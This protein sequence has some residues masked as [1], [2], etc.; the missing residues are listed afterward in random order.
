[1]KHLFLAILLLFPIAVYG[2]H[3]HAPAKEMA[4][5]TLETGLGDINHPVSTS[6]PE[7]QKFFNQ[8]L[9]YVYAFNHEEAI[10]SFK[11]A[12]TLDP[13]LAMAYWGVALALGSNY[14]VPADGPALLEAYSNLQKALQLAPKASEQDRAYI[15][16]LSKRYSSDIN[17]DRHKLEVDYKNAMGQLSKDYPDDLDAATLYAESM[18][19]LRPW[20]LWSLDGK[21]AEDTLEIVATLEGVLR[22][23]PNHSGANHYY[24]HAVEASTNAERALPSADRLGKIAPNA[25]H[26]VH[27][28]SHVYIRTGDYYQAAKANVDAIAVDREYMTK[29]GN[30]GLYPNMY[31]NHNVHF[32]ASASAMNG[33]YADSIKN[34]RDLESNVK[35]VIKAMPMLEMFM[36]YPLVSMTRFGKWDEILKE[37]QPD[38]SLKIVTAFWHF[39]RGSAYAAA[40]DT[41]KADAELAALRAVDQSM[42]PEVRMF[43]NAATDITKVAELE[44]EGKIALARGDKQAGI[45][46][47][48]KAV[49]AEDA[50]Y[51]SEP[52]DWDLPVRE[53]LGGVLLA[54]GDYSGA[55]KVFRAEI[56]RQPRN[57]RALFGLAESLRKQGKEAAAKSVQ[58]E[59]EKA[60]QFA[61]TKLSVGSLTGVNTSNDTAVVSGPSDVQFA[62]VIVKTG[63]RLRYAYKGDPSGT[64]V[65]MLHGYT[66]SWFSFSQVVPLMDK[67]YRVY[68]LDQRGHG[69]SSRPEG[70][71]SMPQFA[72]DVIA[73]MDAM[74]IRQATIVGHS[75]GSFVAQHV[76]SEAPE[77][78]TKLVLVASA[79]TVRNNTVL[80]LQREIDALKET[81]P[82]P[83]TFARD[84]Q[85]STAFQPLA[86]EFLQ[87]VVSESMKMPVHVWREVMAEMLAPEADVQLKKIKTPTLILWGDKENI[88]PRSE[89]DRLV[90]ELRNSVLKVY[91]NTGHALH[92][93]RPERFAKDLQEFIN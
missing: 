8:G 93:E 43:N 73:F 72:A 11:Q 17:V 39:A 91:P 71:Y 87:G 69:D 42:T 53:V 80:G 6:N 19:N 22:R 10:R 18:M 77:R 84:F 40:K 5:V 88:F 50:T 7:A 76:A 47:L 37:P 12:A 65:I 4:P 78:V 26:L 36:P 81:A 23:N 31:Y 49:A 75:M 38:P 24:I 83:E 55:E 21:P 28:P 66:D 1:M 63:V 62:S 52:A 3:S 92:W 89:Q 41:A 16:A 48:N 60:W 68:V 34:A 79:T 25:G 44:L 29:S 15:N 32:L 90:S 14:N 70:G 20:H 58:A 51:Y 82:V 59:F 30:K 56:L 54:N 27:M 61:D 2:Q 33:R 45:D 67:K 74:N 86:P 9:A 85:V 46:L 64:P 35:P 13:Q 57:G